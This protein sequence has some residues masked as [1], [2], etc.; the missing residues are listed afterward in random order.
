M[1]H[2]VF[3]EA[4][5]E[6]LQKSLDPEAATP[7]EIL[8]LE[9]LY[10]LGPI[11]KFFDETAKDNRRQWWES[12]KLE[13]ENLY[14]NEIPGTADEDTVQNIISKLQENEEEVVWIWAA[15]NSHDVCGYYQLMS[16]LKAF[17]GRVFI[18]YLNNLPFIN[19]KRLIFYPDYLRQILPEEFKKARKLN[20]PITLSE[21]ETDPD[22]WERLMKEEKGIRILEGGKKLQQYDYDYYDKTILSNITAEWVKLSRLLSSIYSKIKAGNEL[23]F[24]WRIR[25]MVREGK[26]DIQ[27]DN[28]S[29]KDCEVKLSQQVSATE[30]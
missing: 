12:L 11:G 6:A 21:F 19:E 1:I 27:G 23:Y 25:E 13:N 20:R 8:V 29:L 7:E 4:D 15:Q 9:D 14:K 2:V 28:K 10:E 24:L 5:K 18:L 22:E 3:H 17:Q 26:L 16:A 30:N